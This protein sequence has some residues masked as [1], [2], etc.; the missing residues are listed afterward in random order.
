MKWA[1]LIVLGLAAGGCAKQPT[2]RLHHAEINRVQI[3]FP[4]RLD[5]QMTVVMDVYNPNRYDVAIREMHGNVTIYDRV[6]PI[7][8]RPGGD[9]VWLAS[10]QTTKVRVPVSLPLDLAF[11]IARDA[12]SKPVVYHVVGKADVTATRSMTIERDDYAFD[13]KGEITREHIES[14]IALGL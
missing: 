4:P 11:Q 8:F 13:A 3:A 9:G 12:L 10:K 2:M 5:V 6:T 1:C 7:D 14:S